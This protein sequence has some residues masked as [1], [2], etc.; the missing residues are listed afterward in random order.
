MV[1]L[2]VI[3]IVIMFSSCFF[4]WLLGGPAARDERFVVRGEDTD[5]D[6]KEAGESYNTSLP[7]MMLYISLGP[8]HYNFWSH[9]RPE[10]NSLAS[11]ACNVQ[12]EWMKKGAWGGKG[13]S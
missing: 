7:Q 3:T 11:P 2:T 1:I 4:F 8:H 9:M 10:P 12:G 13:E 5:T 6:I